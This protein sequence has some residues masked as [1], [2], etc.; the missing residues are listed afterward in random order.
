MRPA[1]DEQL[2]WRF[3]TD[4][5]II[6]QFGTQEEIEVVV[7]GRLELKQS[8]PRVGVSTKE[9][10]SKLPDKD[11]FISSE[12]VWSIEEKKRYP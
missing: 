7:L 8:D 10:R 3:D 4:E 9:I 11:V 2:S 12:G 1:I 5:K 6:L